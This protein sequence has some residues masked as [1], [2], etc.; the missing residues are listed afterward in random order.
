MST[1]KARNVFMINLNRI[2]EQQRIDQSDIVTALNTTASTVSDWVNGKKYPRVD[3]M[4]NLAEYLGVRMSTL[5]D[6][7]PIFN[8]EPLETKHIPILGE[9]SCGEPKF[10]QEEF[11]YYAEHGAPIHVDYIL[12]AK[13]DSMIGAGIPDG[14]LV[15][16]RQQSDVENGEIAAVL[17]DDETTLKRVFKAPGELRLVPENPSFRTQYYTGIEL[18]NIRILGKCIFVQHD[19]D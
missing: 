4:Q 8:H 9:I 2:M 6:D 7:Q 19:I 17:V 5:T 13:G 3:A 15:F 18:E 1:S 10:A 16:I 12:K 11:E 14:S